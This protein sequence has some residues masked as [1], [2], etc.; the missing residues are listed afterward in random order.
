M[1]LLV[2]LG[3]LKYNI[4]FRNTNIL[5]IVN[6]CKCL[7][8]NLEGKNIMD[9]TNYMVRQLGRTKNKRHELYCVRRCL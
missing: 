5:S 7:F 9:R 1:M 6:H 4:R 3:V 2:I 8:L